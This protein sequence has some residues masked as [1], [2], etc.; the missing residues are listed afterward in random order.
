MLGEQIGPYVVESELGRGGMGEAY[1]AQDT[2]LQRD[3]ALKILPP[4]FAAE[5]ERLARP[6]ALVAGIR[7]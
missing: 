1:Q 5:P 7:E 2:R 4:E 3:A 6:L